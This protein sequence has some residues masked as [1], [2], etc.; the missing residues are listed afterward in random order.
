LAVT[1]GEP[2]SEAGASP[3]GHCVGEVEGTKVGVV[4]VAGLL[5]DGCGVAPA[6]GREVVVGLNVVGVF[7]VGCFVVG[8]FDVGRLVGL[9]EGRAVGQVGCAEMVLPLEMVTAAFS[10]SMEPRIVPESMVMLCCATMLPMN[11]LAI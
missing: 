1:L 10:A 7:D 9:D 11:M 3:C 5:V 6:A 8:V 4:V 2:H